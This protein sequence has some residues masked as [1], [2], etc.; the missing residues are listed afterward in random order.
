MRYLAPVLRRLLVV[1]ATLTAPIV[2]VQPAAPNAAAATNAAVDH[3]YGSDGVAVLGS[4]QTGTATTM[5]DLGRL[6]V[7]GAG[8]WTPDGQPDPFVLAQRFGARY[9]SFPD[10]SIL[11]VL[12]Q[13]GA[14]ITVTVARQT[15]PALLDTDFGNGGLVTFT[16]PNLGYSVDDIL[17]AGDGYV[18][19]GRHQTLSSP[20]TYTSFALRLDH[21]GQPLSSFGTAGE[22]DF[23]NPTNE[24]LRAATGSGRILL[25]QHDGMTM[26]TESGA[27]IPWS[28][29]ARSTMAS[30]VGNECTRL[31][32]DA[33]GS[34]TV[35]STNQTNTPPWLFRFAAD[36]TLD[37][38]FGTFGH[39]ILPP[40]P[41]G[42]I[43]LP[44]VID[45]SSTGPMVVELGDRSL[46]V[47]RT[48]TSTTTGTRS[49][50]VHRYSAAGLVDPGFGGEPDGSL[51][52][53]HLDGGA[54]H[55]HGN[56]LIVVGT[57]DTP[58]RLIAQAFDV[59]LSAIT[60][61][62]PP[63]EPVPSPTLR[64]IAPFRLFDT[65]PGES[66][67]AA[68]TVTTAPVRP[69]NPMSVHLGGVG[70]LPA[71]GIGAVSL[72]VAVTNAATAGWLK[73]FPCG[74]PPTT[75]NINYVAGQTVSNAVITATTATEICIASFSD[76]DVIVDVNGWFPSGAGIMPIIPFRL[77]DTRPGESLDAAVEVPKRQVGL[78]SILSVHLGG[79]GS[80][81]ASGLGAVSLNVAV[82]NSGAGG[83][84]KVY[85]CGIP[86]PTANINYAV[87]QTVSNAVITATA[88]TEICVVAL[89]PVDVIIDVNAWFPTSAG[90]AP[91]QPFRLFDTR[92]GES[93]DAAISGRTSPVGAHQVVFLS[94][95]GLRSVP[96]AGAS[97]LALNVAVT[98]VRSA[99]WVK[100]YPCGAAPSTANVNVAPGDTVSNAVI[101]SISTAGTIC[102]ESSVT[103]DVIVDVTGWFAG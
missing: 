91:I 97:A 87:G 14:T 70:G 21:A 17:P 74:A 8:R 46:L 18:V 85:P 24:P 23:A 75:A 60:P 81:P 76:V 12:V 96:L 98:N 11:S 71:S 44:E 10:G 36:G 82:T 95:R 58:S 52:L 65:R 37:T 42:L 61:P 30:L 54:L 40:L 6:W 92:P 3:A 27:L 51:R 26:Y 69:G 88:A 90:L 79:A 84:L 2:L 5:D 25:C 66:P 80:L 35:V 45:D 33:D 62:E 48:A 59:T 83:W 94:P 56:R 38:G 41:T 89:S 63:P 93:P 77:I 53:D 86:P 28:S 57:A 47:R 31:A 64:A 4:S 15:P 19:L 39:V 99:G 68:L 72:N 22:M 73:V 13:S 101:T 16:D 103:V 32:L 102:I 100:V 29:A 7:N 50:F 20:T 55:A 49:T 67:D 43:P 9:L 78:G 1:C 34:L